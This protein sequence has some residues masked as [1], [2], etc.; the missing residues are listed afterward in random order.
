VQQYYQ[1]CEVKEEKY[2]EKFLH[3]QKYKVNLNNNL[4]HEEV[5]LKK[6]SDSKFLP[7]ELHEVQRNWFIRPPLLVSNLRAVEGEAQKEKHYVYVP[8]QQSD[9]LCDQVI[10]EEIR[11]FK[12]TVLN[13][14]AR[15]N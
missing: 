8:K 12:E 11:R 10:D 6:F 9:S 5:L 4:N 13:E 2:V 3:L 7:P 1:S 15:K 14:H